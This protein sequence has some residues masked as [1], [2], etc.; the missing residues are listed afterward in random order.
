LARTRH[1]YQQCSIGN[2]PKRSRTYFM[3]GISPTPTLKW[4]VCSSYGWSW[5]WCVGTSG[6]RGLHCSAITPPW[7]DG[8]NAWQH[9]GLWCLHTSSEHLTLRLKLNQTCPITPLHIAEEENS[10]TDI[11]SR[12]FVSKPKWHCRLTLIYSPCSTTSS[13]FPLRTPGPSSKFP[14]RLV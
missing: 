2:G 11:P 4:Q 7:L 6:R 5:N 13:L 12:S 3:K 10:M 9:A 14:T 1:A 8:S